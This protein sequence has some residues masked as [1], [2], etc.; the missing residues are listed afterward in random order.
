MTAVGDRLSQIARANGYLTD[1]G[2]NI[3]YW[4]DPPAEYDT[5]SLIYR[6]PDEE[7]TQVG[8]QRENQLHVEVEGLL[9]TDNP[10]VDG[11]KVIADIIKAIGLDP[12]WSKLCFNTQLVKNE[13]VV[14]TTGKTAVQVIVFVD[15]FYRTSLWGG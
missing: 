4:H 14:E 3:F 7:H 12:T 11:N 5:D 2:T 13:T 10:G 6:D 15:L 9:F 8:N 1:I